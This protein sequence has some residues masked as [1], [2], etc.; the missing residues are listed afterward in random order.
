VKDVEPFG[1]LL[2]ENSR[3]YGIDEGFNRAIA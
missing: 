2:F 1:F 3:H